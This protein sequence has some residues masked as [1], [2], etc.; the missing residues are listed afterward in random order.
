MLVL[1]AGVPP[2]T[3]RMLKSVWVDSV[4]AGPRSRDLGFGL[5]MGPVEGERGRRLG[6]KLE[7]VEC[8]GWC[9]GV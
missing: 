1:G 7:C 4:E 6:I 9:G 2:R 3:S 8:E 5:E